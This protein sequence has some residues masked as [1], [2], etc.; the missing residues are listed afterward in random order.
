MM[1]DWKPGDLALCINQSAWLFNSGI[2]PRAGEIREVRRVGI[3]SVGDIGLWLCGYPGNDFNSGYKADY[4]RKI[5]P[6]RPDAEDAE[7]IRL[8]NERKVPA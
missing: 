8:L 1:D 4:F 2:G 5:Y 3:D 6:H 7:T